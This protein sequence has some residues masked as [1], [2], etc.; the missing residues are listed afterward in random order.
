MSP[1]ELEKFRK[2]VAG[3]GDRNMLVDAKVVLGLLDDL[4]AL[5]R[6]KAEAMAV[7]SGLEEL[8]RALGIPLGVSVTA[9]AVVDAA[10][11][12]RQGGSQDPSADEIDAG[13]RAMYENEAIVDINGDI[14]PWE[15]VRETSPWSVDRYRRAVTAVLTAAE[16]V[17]TGGNRT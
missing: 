7:M 14:V 2:Y 11:E 6:W 16:E 9:R 17:R 1:D 4:D 12:L 15:H 10:L 5:K 13:M 3:V 8:G